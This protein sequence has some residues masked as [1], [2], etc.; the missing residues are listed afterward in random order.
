MSRQKQE[1]SRRR[2]RIEM[3]AWPLVLAL[4]FSGVKIELGRSGGDTYVAV[5]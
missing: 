5:I 1:G 4:V 2:G 3:L